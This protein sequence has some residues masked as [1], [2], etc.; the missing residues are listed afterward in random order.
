MRKTNP[1]VSGREE[2]EE[3]LAELFMLQEFLKPAWQG[4]KGKRLFV[5]HF[6]PFEIENWIV[7]L[8]KEYKKEKSGIIYVVALCG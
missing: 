8:S 6:Y 7:V 5:I 4:G 1:G 3:K 2:K